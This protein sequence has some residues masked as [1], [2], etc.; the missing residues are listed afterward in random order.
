MTPV[1]FRVVTLHLL[2][3]TANLLAF[4]LFNLHTTMGSLES[5]PHFP[6]EETEAGHDS[7][8]RFFKLQRQDSHL[9]CPYRRRF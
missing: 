9:G 8:L 5:L 2:W 3:T 7:T 4:I 1:S 6:N